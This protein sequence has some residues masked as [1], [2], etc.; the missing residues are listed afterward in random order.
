MQYKKMKFW[1]ALGEMHENG[2]VIRSI[3]QERK[4]GPSL[5]IE[6]RWNSLEK[7]LETRE[8]LRGEGFEEENAKR[9]SWK[10]TNLISHGN[11]ENMWEVE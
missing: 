5:V 1:N 2:R 9:K 11:F 8:L 4:D 3:F 7:R 10:P 6:Y